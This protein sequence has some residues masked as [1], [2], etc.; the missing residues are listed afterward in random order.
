MKNYDLKKGKG[1]VSFSEEKRK[2]IQLYM[3]EKIRMDDTLFLKKTAEVFSISETS[4]RRYVKMCIDK[5]LI[6]VSNKSV[7]LSTCNL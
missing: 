3:L 5:K 4:V 6:E 1:S 7:W 2:A